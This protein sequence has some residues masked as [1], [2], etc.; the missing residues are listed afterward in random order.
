[1]DVRGRDDGAA[2]PRGDGAVLPLVVLVH[3]V[4]AGRDDRH[5]S[6]EVI[7]T[8]CS[9]CISIVSF[10]FPFTYSHLDIVHLV[11]SIVPL[12]EPCGCSIPISPIFTPKTFNT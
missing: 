3:H 11:F 1:M 4:L 9:D 8:T 5:A 12:P 2:A 10:R 6:H 7:S